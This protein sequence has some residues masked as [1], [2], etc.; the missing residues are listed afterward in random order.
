LSAASRSRLSNG[1]EVLP[2]ID[3]RSAMARRYRDIANQIV[4]DQGG[5]DA[6]SESRQQLIRR[7]SAACVLAEQMEARLVEGDDIDISDHSLLCS[8]LV[9]ISA[10]IGINRR[11]RNVTPHL[12]DYLED[13]ATSQSG[14]NG[15]F[16]SAPSSGQDGHLKSR[17]D[18]DELE[19]AS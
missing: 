5:I 11:L 12:A 1:K 14:Q 3:G 19:S 15:P 9:R 17:K 18:R 8:T 6:C 16:G 7:F 13:R 10:R 2:D 4:S